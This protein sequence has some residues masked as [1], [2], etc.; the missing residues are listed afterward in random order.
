MAPRPRGQLRL[1]QRRVPPNWFRFATVPHFVRL[2]WRAMS[3]IPFEQ[4]CRGDQCTIARSGLYASSRDCLRQ[5]PAS[6][7]RAADRR[8]PSSTYRSIDWFLSFSEDYTSLELRL[9]S[10]DRDA[11]AVLVVYRAPSVATS[12]GSAF[13]KADTAS[14]APRPTSRSRA[15]QCACRGIETEQTRRSSRLGLLQFQETGHTCPL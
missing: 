13:M 15:R 4:S 1:Y 9:R 8:S 12:S 6:T 5:D 11:Q 14:M 2:Y 10:P 3:A 7:D